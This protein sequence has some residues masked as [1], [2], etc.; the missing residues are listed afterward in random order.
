M[1]WGEAGC[2]AVGFGAVGWGVEGGLAGEASISRAPIR[3]AFVQRNVGRVRKSL[4]QVYSELHPPPSGGRQVISLVR[5]GPQ[6]IPVG[7][8]GVL[9]WARKGGGQGINESNL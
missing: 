5:F 6:L 8:S 1:G 7:L 3:R 2:G 4:G 9:G